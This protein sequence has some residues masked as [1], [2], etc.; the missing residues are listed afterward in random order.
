MCGKLYIGEIKRSIKVRLKE[1]CSDIM[2]NKTKSSAVAEH[3]IKNNHYMC[4]EQAKVIATKYY[5]MRDAFKRRWKLK[6]TL[7]ILI[8]MVVWLL[9][10]FGNLSCGN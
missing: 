5:Y 2:H 8:E 7:R 6:S 3:S 1:H 4:I 10:E 9:V